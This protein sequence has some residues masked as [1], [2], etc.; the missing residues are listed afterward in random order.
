MLKCRMEVLD[1]V[2]TKITADV[3]GHFRAAN[4]EVLTYEG[5]IWLSFE[6]GIPVGGGNFF[7]ITGGTGHWENAA[8][9]FTLSWVELENNMN[10][11]TVTGEVTPP[12]KNHEKNRN[13]QKWNH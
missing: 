5:E 13:G 10:L 12:G 4:T 11:Y 7:D 3:V 1:G 9:Y 8:G 2:T 6:N